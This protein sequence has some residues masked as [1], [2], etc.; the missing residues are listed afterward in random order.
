MSQQSTS[1]P[2]PPLPLQNQQISAAIVSEALKQLRK[3][4][5]K[6]RVTSAAK[7][8]LSDNHSKH[9]HTSDQN[10][11]DAYKSSATAGTFRKFD[12]EN[13]EVVKLPTS[14]PN[15]PPPPPPPMPLTLPGG[16]NSANKRKRQVPLNAQKRRQLKS[17]SSANLTSASATLQNDNSQQNLVDNICKEIKTINLH[18]VKATTAQV[19]HILNPVK[20]NNGNNAAKNNDEINICSIKPSVIA[21]QQLQHQ[22]QPQAARKRASSFSSSTTTTITR[23]TNK[24]K[25][26]ATNK[27]DNNDVQSRATD[28]R[29][30][31]AEKKVECGQEMVNKSG[32]KHD[33]NITP[34]VY[35][36]GKLLYTSPHSTASN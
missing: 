19:E 8:A 5:P 17:P 23:K 25:T 35:H 12:D 14:P 20:Q 16:A 30:F 3:T 21:Q 33:S 18:S 13:G 24:F 28:V 31:V 15:A 1:T 32:Q 9:D 34:D 27:V 10:E 4:S 26:T 7:E 11:V 29:N 6:L 36:Y 22:P 2:S